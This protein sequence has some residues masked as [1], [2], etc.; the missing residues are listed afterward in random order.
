MT[1]IVTKYIPKSFLCAHGE[2]V[3][4]YVFVHLSRCVCVCVRV[5][6]GLF[7]CL[8]ACVKFS[9][10]SSRCSPP[11]Q[12]ALCHQTKALCGGLITAGVQKAPHRL[13]HKT[14][15]DLAL[16]ETHWLFCGAVLQRLA[17]GSCGAAPNQ[18][19]PPPRSS[20]RRSAER[21]TSNSSLCSVHVVALNTLTQA[22]THARTRA[23]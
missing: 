7:R 11:S 18:E 17:C 6:F 8:D 16:L 21:E 12:H 22:G 15:T 9:F 1:H 23:P 5:Q 4:V 13:V 20:E 19:N 14:T 3:C 10:I 2:H